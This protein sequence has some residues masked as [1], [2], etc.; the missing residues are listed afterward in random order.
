MKIHYY[1]VTVLL[2]LFTQFVIVIGFPQNYGGYGSDKGANNQQQRQN[3]GYNYGNFGNQQPFIFS[4]LFD[5]TLTTPNYLSAVNP[6][7]QSINYGSGQID[8]SILMPQG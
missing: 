3:N 2:A 1:K 8:I 4:P 6:Y 7:T 5:Q